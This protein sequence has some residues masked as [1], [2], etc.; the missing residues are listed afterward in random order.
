MI[1]L[2]VIIS[3]KFYSINCI[4]SYLQRLFD[5]LDGGNSN[6]ING[7]TY[8]VSKSDDSGKIDTLT[9]IEV[10]QGTSYADIMTADSSGTTSDTFKGGAGN[11]QLSGGAGAD[12]LY[13]EDGDDTRKGGTGDDYLDGGNSNEINGGIVTGK[14][15]QEI[16]RAHV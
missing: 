10:V 7:D 2:T 5:Y 11:D 16:G 1:T 3:W 12:T 4:W 8:S 13:G 15:L 14:H 9:N 6:E